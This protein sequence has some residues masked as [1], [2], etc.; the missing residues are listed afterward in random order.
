VSADL[1]AALPV[2]A[3]PPVDWPY[4]VEKVRA[5]FPILGRRIHASSNDSGVPLVYLDSAATSQKPASV[6]AA[7][8]EYNERYNANVHRGIHTLAEEAT[9]LYEQGRDKLAAFLGAA[10][11]REIIFGKNVTEGLNL[12]AHSLGAGL[13]PGDEVVV[14][15]MEHH[16]NLVPW[17]LACQRSGATLRWFSL[18]DDGRLDLGAA[19]RDGLINARTKVVAFVHRR[20]PRLDLAQDARPH[21]N[22]RPLGT[23]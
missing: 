12:L 3:P 10:D 8:R 22:R 6:L 17:Q 7:E 2:P 1:V 18:T 20:L 23:L 16:S 15:E 5:D 14:T 9:A 21:R 19:D 13:K 4:D 11:P